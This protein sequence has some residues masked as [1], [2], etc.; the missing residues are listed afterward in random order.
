MSMFG[1]PREYT[2]ND[3]ALPSVHQRSSRGELINH[4]IK[5]QLKFLGFIYLPESY[6]PAKA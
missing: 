2:R 6:I 5:L 3:D 4:S 1:A